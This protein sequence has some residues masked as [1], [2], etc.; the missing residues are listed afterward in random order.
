MVRR[1]RLSLFGHVARMP[2]SVPA[3]IVL[4][5]ACDVRDRVPPYP[6]LA[7]TVG[8][9]SHCLAAQDLFRLWPVSWRRPQLYPGSGRV[10]NVHYVPSALRS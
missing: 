2:K 6:K 8:S 9:S 4:R 3:K 5:I 10:E 1:R 7:Q